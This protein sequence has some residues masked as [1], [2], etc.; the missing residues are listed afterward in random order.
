MTAQSGGGAPALAFPP[1]FSLPSDEDVQRIAAALS[2]IAELGSDG[3]IFRYGRVPGNDVD[4]FAVVQ[5]EVDT[6]LEIGKLDIHFLSVGGYRVLVQ[7]LDPI[8]CEPIITGQFLTGNSEAF[9]DLQLEAKTNRPS[10]AATRRLI[11]CGFEW[12]AA[13]RHY[14]QRYESTEKAL[15]GYACVT[16]LAYALV[17]LL[18]ATAYVNGRSTFI[19]LAEL[20]QGNP[21][22][23]DARTISREFKAL[24]AVP[25]SVIEDLICRSELGLVAHNVP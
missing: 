25:A 9:D 19:S 23:R 16:N 2:L 15:D 14:F 17:Y 24:N 18:S 4:L 10:A 5:E 12:F 7:Q 22:L 11:R 1:S 21:L 6:R 8:G 20:E 13:A 3:F